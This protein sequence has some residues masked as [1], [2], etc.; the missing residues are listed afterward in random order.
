MHDT[1]DRRFDE[2]ITAGRTLLAQ[3]PRSPVDPGEPDYWLPKSRLAEYQQWI[4]SA[5]NLLKVVARKGS[6]Y[7]TEP[8]RLMARKND[9][10][11]IPSS[12]FAELLGTL[13]SAKEEWKHG[14]L[15]EI[16][17]VV[18]AA[19]FDDFLDHAAAFHRGGKKLEASVL[20]SAVLEDSMKR[21][22][23]K[24]GVSSSGSLDPLVDRL[25]DA[26]VFTPVKAKRIKAY[27]GLRNRALHAEWDQ[28][29]LKDVGEVIEGVRELIED[30]L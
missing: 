4:A 17:Y 28:F 22:A 7:F 3:I 23:S 14:L 18:A 9:Q 11:G 27:A 10:D 25:V 24:H 12:R 6:H 29:D 5:S 21:I 16:E 19:T 8:D 20:A 1:I 2:L 15:R 13:T 26:E 30:Y